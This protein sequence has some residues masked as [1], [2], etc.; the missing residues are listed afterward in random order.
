M[1]GP[2][3]FLWRDRFLRF[4]MGASVQLVSAVSGVLRNKWFAENLAASGVGILAQVVSNQALLGTAAGMG[5]GL[6]VARM[7]G[8][9][10]AEKDP[11]AAR[12][13]VW[14]SFS[15]LAISGS[16]VVTLGLFFAETISQALLGTPAYAALIRISMVGIAG[17]AFQ[18]VLMGLFAGRS[19]LKAP[20]AFAL[21]GGGASLIAAFLLVPRWGLKGAIL[22]AAILFP[23]GCAGALAIHWRVYAP[24]LTPP[25]ERT[26][27]SGLARSLLTV[28]GAGLV[29]ALV[30]QGTFLTLRSHY[31]RANGVEV[32]GYLQAG[33][34]VTQ[35]V[36]ALFYVYLGSYAF[37]QISGMLG[38][39]GTRAYT[40]KHWAPL[41]L[42]AAVALVATRLGA[43]PLLRLLYS[44]RFDSA[45]PLM[46]WCL[47][48]EFGRIGLMTWSLGALPLGGAKLWFPMSLVFPAA[49]AI[50]YAAFV[51]SGA[52]ALSLPRAYAVAGLVAACVGGAIMSRR[53]VTLGVRDLA[54][55]VGGAVLLVALAATAG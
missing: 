33:I 25:R 40:R 4:S 5:L 10:T 26:L 43:L 34:A 23:A 8:A 49:L 24:V 1:P 22:S 38:A 18:G 28:A 53:G 51:A 14:A 31:V 11:L 55:F 39:D 44:H 41:I 12:R 19:D 17:I 42:L 27:T 13:T 54:V 7:V 35:Q 6:P 30:D 47:V 21:V 48:G 29:S 20:L 32:N 36:G 46:A 15:L 52:G 2:R 16:I 9:A 45:H 37:G 3:F 50:S